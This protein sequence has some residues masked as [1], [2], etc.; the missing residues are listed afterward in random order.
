[1][2]RQEAAF[3][4]VPRGVMQGAEHIKRLGM[5]RTLTT[6][7]AYFQYERSYRETFGMHM[8]SADM[9]A[10]PITARLAKLFSIDSV[11]GFPYA[12]TELAPHLSR[13]DVAQI[14]KAV[15]LFGEKAS[16]TQEAN[17]KE[18]YPHAHVFAGYASIE[19]QSVI[20]QPCSESLAHGG[21]DVHAVEEYFF[22]EFIDGQKP[23]LSEGSEGEI[24]ITSLRPL[25]FPLIRYRTGDTARITS[26]SCPCGAQTPRFSIVGRIDADRLRV[27]GGEISLAE[28][29]RALKA[30]G[31]SASSIELTY[32]ESSPP[33][34][35]C[36]VFLSRGTT[37]SPL[38]L[39][40][41]F[42]EEFRLT[43]GTTYARLVAEGRYGPLTMRFLLAPGK[44]AV[45]RRSG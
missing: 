36:G 7:G 33:R 39:A 43:P 4:G 22:V 41:R 37:T 25:A 20:A 38:E 32:L 24:V 18:A 27:A 5:H 29:H 40:R 21:E 44:S 31:L 6:T 17:I 28:A 23:V 13:E 42:A 11:A 26:L 45:V 8:M 34:I 9:R 2:P 16:P 30:I 12:M 1:M 15:E 14:I 35:D 10:L 19:A 3:Y